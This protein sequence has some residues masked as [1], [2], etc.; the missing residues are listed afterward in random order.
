MLARGKCVVLQ[1]HRAGVPVVPVFLKTKRREFQVLWAWVMMS[2]TLFPL[3]A[4][5]HRSRP[6]AMHTMLRL[7]GAGSL[8]GGFASSGRGALVR[9]QALYVVKTKIAAAASAAW[10]PAR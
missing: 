4:R 3:A 7:R 6:A 5:A 8:D 1:E 10:P 9:R 2:I